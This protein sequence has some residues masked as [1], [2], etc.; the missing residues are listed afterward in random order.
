MGINVSYVACVYLKLTEIAGFDLCEE[1]LLVSVVVVN[2]NGP[3]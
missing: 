2:S 1:D 3:P